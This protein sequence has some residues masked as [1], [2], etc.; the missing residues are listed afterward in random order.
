MVLG[1]LSVIWILVIGV[2]FASYATYI[3]YERF[4]AT[5]ILHYYFEVLI[6]ACEKILGKLKGVGDGG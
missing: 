1:V 5:G 3:L 2:V 6:A 4:V